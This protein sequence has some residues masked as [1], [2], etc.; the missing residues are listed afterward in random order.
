MRFIIVIC[1]ILLLFS[2]AY[3][4]HKAN[5]QDEYTESIRLVTQSVKNPKVA[6]GFSFTEKHINR[7]GDSVSIALLKIY[8]AEALQNPKNIK[9]YLPIIRAA[10][11]SPK[12]IELIENRK[13]EVTIFLLTYLEGRVKDENLKTQISDV[14]KFIKEETF[15]E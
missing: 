4:Q 11:T 2:S 8:D 5:G 12:I 3:T 7:L 13:P 10:F 9:N 14:I 1:S 6:L 15:S